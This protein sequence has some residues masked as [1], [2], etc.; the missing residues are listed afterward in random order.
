MQ[1]LILAAIRC[2]LMF[3]AVAAL[4]VVYPA[5]VQAVPLIPGSAVLLPGTTV[6]A[7]PELAGVV[8]VDQL[9]SFS[10]TIP[11]DQHITGM[12][13]ERVVRE[14]GSGTLDFYWRVFNDISSLN[15]LG[16]FRLGQFI[17]GSYDA[18][19]RI[20]GL[21]TVNPDNAFLFP[22]PLGDVNFEF[23]AGL[24]PGEESRFMFLHTDA[25]SYGLTASMDVATPGTFE[26]S[27]SFRTFGPR[28]PDGGSTL[29]LA[30]LAMSGLALL[31]RKVA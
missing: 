3:T 12:I 10:V 5:S 20:D 8:L 11:T 9:V 15:N 4:S 22:G 28:V 2:S 14:S 27:Q 6:A 19:W 30:S 1:T 13:Q 26:E 24:A 7:R 31:R 17:T 21:G 29:M 23:T 16:F 18:D 25:T